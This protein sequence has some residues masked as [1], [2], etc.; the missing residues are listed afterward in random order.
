MGGRLVAPLK[1][2]RGFAV[3]LKLGKNWVKDAEYL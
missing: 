2:N 3:P 1:I